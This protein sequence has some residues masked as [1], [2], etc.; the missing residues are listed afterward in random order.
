MERSACYLHEASKNMAFFHED[1]EM[2]V[3]DLVAAKEE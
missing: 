2:L 1:V 3:T